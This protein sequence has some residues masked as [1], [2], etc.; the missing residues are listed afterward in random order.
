MNAL[1]LYTYLFTNFNETKQKSKHFWSVMRIR[2]LIQLMLN[3]FQK[4]KLFT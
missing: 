3:D 1:Y 2:F 4:Q